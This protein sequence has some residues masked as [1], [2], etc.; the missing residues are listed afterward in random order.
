MELSCYQ[1]RTIIYFQF[2]CTKPA[3]ECHQIMC[4]S[5]DTNVVSYDTM[6]VWCRKFK[7]KDND[8]Q[9]AQHFIRPI[10]KDCLHA[11]IRELAKELDISATSITHTMHHINLMYKFNRWVSHELTQAGKDRRVRTCTNLLEY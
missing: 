2:C 7:N 1:I 3:T 9:E 11:T 8:I 4:T 6:K 5:I 10:E